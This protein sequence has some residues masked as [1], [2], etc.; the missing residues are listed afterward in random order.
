MGFLSLLREQFSGS[1][2]LLYLIGLGLDQS[3]SLKSLRIL[4]ECDKIYYETTHL[5]SSMRM[6]LK[7]FRNSWEVRK[8]RAS[9]EFLLRMAET[10]WKPLRIPQYPWFV[11]VILWLLPRIKAPNES[12]KA[13]NPDEG[14]SRIVRYF[15]RWAE[16]WVYILTI[17]AG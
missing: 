3:P 4:K 14:D 2:K 10:S 16:S 8:L 12:T 9:R 6:C 5:Q 15:Q 1:R 11:L 7:S 17:S 13:G